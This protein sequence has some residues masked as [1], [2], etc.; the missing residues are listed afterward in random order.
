MARYH[1]CISDDVAAT[2]VCEK[3]SFIHKWSRLFVKKL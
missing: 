3:F 1:F 2:E